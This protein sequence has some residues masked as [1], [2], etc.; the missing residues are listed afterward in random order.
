M[1]SWNKH[2][3]RI[4]Q[5]AMEQVVTGT[6]HETEEVYELDTK[7]VHGKP[8]FLMDKDTIQALQHFYF[9]AAKNVEDW[10]ERAPLPSSDATVYAQQSTGQT[11]KSLQTELEDILRA[12]VIPLLFALEEQGSL[13]ELS[14]FL[15]LLEATPPFL[16][17]LV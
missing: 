1:A 4:F 3:C 2:A 15:F 9:R 13:D 7:T 11:D 16:T 10:R 14:V 8:N 5:I 17:N 12:L 6:R